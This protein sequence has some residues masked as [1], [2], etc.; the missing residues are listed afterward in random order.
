[1]SIIDRNIVITN[2]ENGAN[3]L[4]PSQKLL[5]MISGSWVAQ[6]LYA[7]A[8]LSIAELLKDGPQHIDQLASAVEADP[9]SLYRLLRALA[10]V[11]VF[12]EVEDSRFGLTPIGEV[13]QINHPYSLRALAILW[14]EEQFEAW[15]NILTS[16]KTGQCAYEHRTGINF[17]DYLNQ[18]T[19][20][21]RT[22][23]EAMIS[24]SQQT[25]NS[26]V[27]AYDFSGF[28]KVIDVG[29]GHGSLISSI[30]KANPNLKGV[31][32]DIP[33][34]IEGAKQHIQSAGISNRC[35]LVAGDFLKSVP[36]G[37]DAYILSVIIHDW[38]DEH[39]ITILKNCHN[40][41]DKNGKLLLVEM[42]IPSGNDPYFGKWLDLHMLVMHRGRERN[43]TE[44]RAILDA[45]GFKLTNI[46]PTR[47]LPS[48]IEAVPV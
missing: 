5:Q 43:E 30:L 12:I 28:N 10:S 22:F 8:K 3:H 23:N 39:S 38:D 26:V 21:A 46:M 6:S 48:V 37:G 45:A 16:V 14:G 15:S 24:Y 34:A 18:R 29:G 33:H 9:Q 42:V 17:F 4:T 35:E 11:E 27:D 1:M 20:A 40:A 47:F 31:L 25:H 44:Y 36:S 41:I 7:V 13:L 19:E 2:R 32:F